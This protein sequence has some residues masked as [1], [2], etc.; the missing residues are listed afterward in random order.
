MYETLASRVIEELPRAVGRYH[1]I[2]AL[3]QETLVD[4][5]ST[6]PQAPL[7]ARIAQ[8]FEEL[9]GADAE[10]NAAML[11][12]HFGEAEGVPGPGKLVRFPL[13]AGARALVASVDWLASMLSTGSPPDILWK[14]STVERKHKF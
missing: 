5:L 12:F 3:I 8:V 4:K 14:D 2:H 11:A 6:T 10:A 9:D 13:L 7:H 1:F